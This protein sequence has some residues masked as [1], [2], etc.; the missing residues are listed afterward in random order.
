M[1]LDNSSERKIHRNKKDGKTYY[2]DI[3]LG[4]Y[5]V[6]GDSVVLL[7]QVKDTDNTDSNNNDDDD[8][9]MLNVELEELQEMISK[10]DDGAEE[11]AEQQQ[12]EILEWDFDK[13]LQA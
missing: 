10:D 2:A 7:G 9:G 3:P 13:D 8:A 12:E 1:I 5:I 11:K 4:L 6:R